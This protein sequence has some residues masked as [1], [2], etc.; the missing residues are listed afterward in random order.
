[1]MGHVKFSTTLASYSNVPFTLIL[2]NNSTPVIIRPGDHLVTT[3]ADQT[4]DVV[5]PNLTV[6]LNTQT[7]LIS[8][9]APPNAEVTV[10]ISNGDNNLAGNGYPQGPL[11][12]TVT[13]QGNY[14][15]NTPL[16][17]GDHV[18]VSLGGTP[19]FR[20]DSTAPMI[21]A[22]LYGQQLTVL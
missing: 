8:G 15:V 6:A 9:Q 12:T 22:G 18:D 20:A 10:R 13:P 5:E 4:A 16:R 17:A 7:G 19:G 2:S 11:T 3:G 1:G 21:R 14:Q